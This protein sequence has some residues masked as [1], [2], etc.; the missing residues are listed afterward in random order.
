MICDMSVFD[1]VN[2]SLFGA[3]A[4]IKKGVEPSFLTW[5]TWSIFYGVES[6]HPR[7]A[8]CKVSALLYFFPK[9]KKK[10]N[11][12]GLVYELSGCGFES[13]CS[14]LNFRHGA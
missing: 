7:E 5:K 8:I 14:H 6:K 2:F 10:C 9:K 3:C 12:P 13:R 4:I 11:T 1:E